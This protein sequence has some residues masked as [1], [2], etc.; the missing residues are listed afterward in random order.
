MT[1]TKT[2]NNGS[3]RADLEADL[4]DEVMEPQRQEDTGKRD[5]NEGSKF[6]KEANKRDR[7]NQIQ[8]AFRRRHPK[9]TLDN[10]NALNRTTSSAGTLAEQA[11]R[12][13]YDRSENPK[14]FVYDNDM[15][16]ITTM[17]SVRETAKKNYD[18]LKG[19]KHPLLGAGY[20]I[21]V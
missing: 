7:M 16:S 3:R 5:V 1:Q 13:D 17:F 21:G 2:K 19:G 15:S 18:T 20:A 6:Q 4:V 12:G 11:M 14:E 9:R 8:S 10:Y